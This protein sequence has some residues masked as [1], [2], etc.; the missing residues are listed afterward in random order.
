MTK[1]DLKIPGKKRIDYV[2]FAEAFMLSVK[3]TQ[4]N[5][6]LLYS[7]YVPFLYFS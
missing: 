7:R 1:K 3:G 2:V 5:L 4:S 6:S